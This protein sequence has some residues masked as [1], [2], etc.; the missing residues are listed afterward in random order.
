MK[1]TRLLKSFFLI[2]VRGIVR[3]LAAFFRFTEEDACALL[4]AYG[5]HALDAD[6]LQNSRPNVQ[7]EPSGSLGLVSDRKRIGQPSGPIPI[8]VHPD[9]ARANWTTASRK[10]A[11]RKNPAGPSNLSPVQNRR[12]ISAP[13]PPNFID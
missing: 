8:G 5:F 10:Q 12:P 1:A 9:F 2:S 11:D 4:S 7:K 13:P 6:S 3:N